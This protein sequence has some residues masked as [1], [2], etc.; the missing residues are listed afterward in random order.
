MSCWAGPRH[1]PGRVTKR[2]AHS[3]QLSGK[4]AATATDAER[5]VY[6]CR[7]CRLVVES[8]QLPEF[9]CGEIWGGVK[10]T[11]AAAT[12]KRPPCAR[13]PIGVSNAR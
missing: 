13:N 10:I 8:I 2:G 12:G 11:V 9:K 1:E 7:H 6:V 3:W 4:I 5:G